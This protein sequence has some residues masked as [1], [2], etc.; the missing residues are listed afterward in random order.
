MCR[1]CGSRDFINLQLAVGT[2]WKRKSGLPPINIIYQCDGCSVLFTDPKKWSLTIDEQKE[3]AE[4]LKSLNKVAEFNR[5]PIVEEW[6][7]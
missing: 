7:G 2:L 3:R 5:L 4:L 1:Q 6:G